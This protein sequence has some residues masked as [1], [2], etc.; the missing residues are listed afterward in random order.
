MQ[1]IDDRL[2][3][4]PSDLTGFLECEHK[5]SLE[6][7]R[8]L[9]GL[10]IDRVDSPEAEILRRHGVD[11]ERSWLQH[12][13][14][15]GLSVI[16]IPSPGD[17]W[18][19]AAELTLR[20]MKAGAAVVY[21]AVFVDAEWRGIADFLVRVDTP[22]ELG[23]WSYEVWDTKL[24]RKTK[25]A[26]VFQLAFYSE[27]LERICGRR[28]AYMHVILGTNET[29]RLRTDDFIS[30]YRSVQRRF[31]SFVSGRPATYPLP[32]AHCSHCEFLDACEAQWRR[33]DHLSLV[34]NIRRDQVARLQEQEIHT[35]A[36]L[37]SSTQLPDVKIGAATLA[38]LRDQARLQVQCRETGEH[39]YSLIPHQNERG[40]ALLPQPTSD[41]LFFDMEGDPFFESSGGL[42][43]LFGVAWLDGEA[44]RYQAWWAKNRD[45]EARA[46]EGL[47]DFVRERLKATPELHVYHYASYERTKLGTLAQQH[48]TR[49]EELD[50]LL[51][52]DVFVDLYRVV[53]QTLRTSHEG[54]S[55]KDI[56]QFF[57]AA[58]NDGPV[59][60]ALDSIVEFERWREAGDDRILETI[61]RYNQDDCVSTLRLRDWLVGR[62]AEAE[63][64]FGVAIPWRPMPEKAKEPV[65]D[66]ADPNAAL[67]QSLN[68]AARD[69]L[70]VEPTRLL[71]GL[72]DYHRREDKPEW[73]AYFDRLESSTQ[74][75]VDDAEA[76]AGL[77]DTGHVIAP[78]G[79]AKSPTFVLSFPAQEYKLGVGDR[80][81]DFA[82]RDGAGEIVQI[83]HD[84]RHLHLKRGPKLAHVPLPV[85]I[86]AGEPFGSVEH[87]E[88]VR[89]V[90]AYF[91][92]SGVVRAERWTAIADLLLRNPP[93]VRDRQIGAHVQ[94]LDFGEQLAIVRGLDRSCL[95]VQGPPG[96][97]KTWTGARLVASLLQ[98]GKRVGVAAFSH[99]AIHNFLEE[100]ER[101][102]LARSFRFNGVKKATSGRPDSHFD[103]INIRSEEKLDDCLN[104]SIRLLAG[105]AFCFAPL[106]LDDAVDYLFIDEAG[107]LSLGDAV[108]M[109]TAARNLVFLGDPQQLPH[110]SHGIHPAGV[111]VSVLEHYMNGQSVVAGDRGLFLAR[112]FRMHPDLC[113]FVSALSYEG[114]LESDESCARQIVMS[115][116]ASGTGIRFIPI[117]HSDNAQMSEEEA[118]V[119]A[120]E[121]RRLL[122]DGRFVDRSGVERPLEPS[123]VLVVAPYNMHVRCLRER[124]PPGVEVGTVDKFQGREAPVVFFSMATSSGEDMPRN[125]RFLFSRNRLNVALSRARCL[126]IV[127]ASPRLLEID[128]N[129]IDEMRLVNG[130]CRFAEESSSTD[131]T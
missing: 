29:E 8:H 111:G 121:V 117:E 11:H 95:I 57:L 92:E 1:R 93:R 71:A 18:N 2:I 22:C 39:T 53:R 38:A 41:D 103:T 35:V 72:L 45:E 85:A 63:A 84:V 42:E 13:K 23:L 7:G 78:Q 44:P 58:A 49:E 40:F 88:A 69:P 64:L 61:E 31:G 124:L 25:P 114:Q 36:A 54:Y 56:R 66:P 87:R 27:Q 112:T 76:I 115:S 6:I 104:P 97:G 9:D 108:A 51:R 86:V 100:L 73:W 26:Y 96:S 116:G 107:Q 52:R 106:K 74:Q 55:L 70:D 21:Q 60:T 4:S 62:K 94:T 20:A 32:V 113:R 91:N 82:S 24:A 10:V 50:D 80:P 48:A 46:F 28:P 89:R 119:V 68:N 130:L 65:V 12:F 120:L 67:R 47:V 15:T 30:Y 16:E 14:D 110:I 79:R 77:S 33:D 43:Y 125:M 19:A 17:D 105:T 129:T 118:A 59:T 101:V 3:L 34:A 90:A 99:R 83:E 37:A 5:S 126:S 122:V 127:V 128:C 109:G 75:L 81:T 98:D 131:A 123:D 102:A